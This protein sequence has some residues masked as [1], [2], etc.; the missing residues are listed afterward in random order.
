MNQ[1]QYNYALFV[2]CK[3]AYSSENALLISF[4]EL[5]LELQEEPLRIYGLIATYV[6]VF[7]DSLCGDAAASLMGTVGHQFK[8]F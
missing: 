6:E 3:K 5:V 1:R 4:S 2:V 8:T 7:E